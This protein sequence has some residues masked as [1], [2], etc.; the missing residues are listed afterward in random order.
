MN[1]DKSTAGLHYFCI[2]YM[3]TKFKVVIYN[4]VFV[5]FNSV[6]NLIVFFINH[7]LVYLWDLM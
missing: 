3:L 2:F 6:S 4:Y 1:F 5:G 7:F